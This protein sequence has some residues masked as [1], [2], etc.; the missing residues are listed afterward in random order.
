M[1]CI[2]QTMHFFRGE[3]KGDF[4]SMISLKQYGCLIFTTTASDNL[5]PSVANHTITVARGLSFIAFVSENIYFPPSHCIMS[6]AVYG[7]RGQ[8]GIHCTE[9]LD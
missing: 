7:K 8:F 9:C 4:T 5:C 2:Y 3:G 1:L 6:L